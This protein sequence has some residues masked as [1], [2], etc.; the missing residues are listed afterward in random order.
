MKLSTHMRSSGRPRG[1]LFDK[2]GTLLDFHASWQPVN[3]IAIR[4]AAQGDPAL[5][6]RLRTAGGLHPV[7]QYAARSRIDT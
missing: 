4:F 7:T 6:A 3:D 1:L 5:E 2:D